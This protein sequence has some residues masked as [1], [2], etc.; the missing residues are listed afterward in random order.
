MQLPF[1]SRA[2]LA[3]TQMRGHHDGERLARVVM[4]RQ[5]TIHKRMQVRPGPQAVGRQRRLGVVREILLHLRETLP[6]GPRRRKAVP[7]DRRACI[8]DA[9]VVTILPC[10]R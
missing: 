8:R 2:A 3:A 10:P 4:G 5:L 9:S 7:D 6:V 1:E